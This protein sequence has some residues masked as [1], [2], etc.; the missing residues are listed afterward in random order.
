[1]IAKN[2]KKETIYIG[3]AADSIVLV[4]NSELA[5]IKRKGFVV[6]SEAQKKAMPYRCFKPINRQ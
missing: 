1:L 6:K 4:A 3:E 2:I 5:V